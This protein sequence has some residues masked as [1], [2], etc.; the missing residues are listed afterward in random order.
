MKPGHAITLLGFIL[1]FHT[2]L[3]AQEEKMGYTGSWIIKFAPLS[4]TDSDIG[5]G[6]FAE[7]RINEFVGVQLGADYL[8]MGQDMEQRVQSATGVRLRPELRMYIPSK[9][10]RKATPR[11]EMYAGLEI[12]YKYVNTSFAEWV[13]VEDDFGNRFS[14]YAD[15]T[16]KNSAIGPVVKMGC[17]IYIGPLRNFIADASMGIGP[18]YN[19]I[20][21]SKDAP[22]NWYKRSNFD[23]G[24]SYNR[25]S[26]I[27]PYFCF[28]IRI[29][30]RL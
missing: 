19:N 2:R 3:F 18:V 10:R 25:Y 9:R 14:R 11:A 20:T 26:G 6:A 13:T 5:L 22:F 4:I 24:F 15:Y 8:G 12:T 30:Y 17:Q 21:A 27:R 23:D 29:G 1:L 28:D 16:T 7:Y